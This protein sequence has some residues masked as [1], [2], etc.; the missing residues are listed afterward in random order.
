MIGIFLTGSGRGGRE[1]LLKQTEEKWNFVFHE[2]VFFGK[3]THSII[4]LIIHTILEFRSKISLL[5][6]IL[7]TFKLWCSFVYLNLIF[8][9]FLFFFFCFNLRE[10]RKRLILVEWMSAQHTYVTL[11]FFKY[12]K[13]TFKHDAAIFIFFYHFYNFL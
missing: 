4:S 2:W 6:I 9:C 11:T 12:K 8:F 3:Q 10:K 13:M 5:K 1:D 7:Q